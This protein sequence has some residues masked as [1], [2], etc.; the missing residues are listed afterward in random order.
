MRNQCTCTYQYY[1]CEHCLYIRGDINFPD[2]TIMNQLFDIEE[3][4]INY[5]IRKDIIDKNHECHVEFSNRSFTY[6]DYTPC[7]NNINDLL[8]VFSNA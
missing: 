4:L 2:L 7:I 6:D 3:K 5:A 1:P 8:N